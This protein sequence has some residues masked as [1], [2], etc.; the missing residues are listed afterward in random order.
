MAKGPTMES[1]PDEILLIIVK[2]S[3]V[4]SVEKQEKEFPSYLRQ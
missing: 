4:V 2:Y 1:L 3:S